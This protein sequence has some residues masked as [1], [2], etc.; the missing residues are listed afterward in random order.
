MADQVDTQLFTALARAAE[1]RTG[2]LISQELANTAWAFAMTD[3]ANT[4]LFMALARQFAIL[5][6]WAS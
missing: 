4:P 2:E 3:R 1:Q 6:I 5:E